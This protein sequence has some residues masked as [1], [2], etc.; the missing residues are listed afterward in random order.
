MHRFAMLAAVAV[1]I[2]AVSGIDASAQSKDKS[3]QQP[4]AAAPKPSTPAAESGLVGI[5]LY[6]TGLKLIQ[7]Y[8]SPDEIQAVGIGGGSIGPVGGGGPG[9]VGGPAAGPPG[10][11]R[12]GGGG[13]GAAA[14]S[15]DAEHRPPSAGDFGFADAMLNFQGAQPSM[16]PGAPGGPQGGGGGLGLPGGRGGG[17]GG[18]QMGPGGGAQQGQTQRVMFTRWVYNRSGSKYA[19][20]LDKQNRI[21]Q[22]E[23]IGISDPKVKTARGVTFGAPFGK[24]VQLYGAPDGYEIGGDNIVVRFLLRQK[25]AFRLSRLGVNKPHVVTG[26]VVAGGKT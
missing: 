20:V 3:S 23:A 21:V 24:L 25:V 16:V 2:L 15:I 22:I 14:A 1:G 11:G 4:K 6:D 9:G 26:I 7:T 18:G 5:K 12:P 10:G 17:G 19:F 13:G 8:G